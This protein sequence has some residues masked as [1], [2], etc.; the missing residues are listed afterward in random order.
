[1]FAV[2]IFEDKEALQKLK[3]AGEITAKARNYGV[4]LVKEGMLAAELAD[5]I[6]RK[7]FDLGAKPAFQACISVNDVAAHYA[8]LLNDP[9]V[10]HEKDYVKL[11]IGAHI[12]GYIAD[13][14]VTVRLAGKDD[15]IK[16]SEKMLE[17]AIKMF[18]PG[19]AVEEASAAMEEVADGFGLKSIGN[20]TGHSIEQYSLH[21]GINVPAVKMSAPKVLSEGE[22]FAIEPFATN[23]KGWVK[24]SPPPTI[25]RWIAD[26]PQRDEVARK[27]LQTAKSDWSRL[28]FAKRWVQQKFGL[29]IENALRQ[30]TA[31]GALYHYNILKEQSGGMVAQAE[32][33]LI[34]AD[35][36][37][38]TTL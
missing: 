19:T 29:N 9:L 12:D 32:H 7:I 8:P 18:R 30:L 37:I 20:L 6:E 2:N 23:G 13:T 38:I 25:F 26:V 27:I 1:M 33:T 14:A 22:V 34:V 10:L 36:P 24:D 15:I 28:P 5:K 21:A 11:D 17:T 35:K 3:L 16:C 31:S 4:K